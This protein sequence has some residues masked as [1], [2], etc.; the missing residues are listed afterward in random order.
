MHSQHG[1]PQ[2][3]HDQLNVIG[4]HLWHLKH[5]PEFLEDA[6]E[7]LPLLEVLRTD[8]HLVSKEEQTRL[9]K[10]LKFSE[11]ERAEFSNLFR[12]YS[13]K[14]Q[15]KLTRELLKRREDW[16]D[17]ETSEDK[18]LQQYF[19]QD[20]FG[21]PQGRPPGTNLLSLL[22]VYLVKDDGR[23]KARCVCNGSKNCRGTVT[24]AETYASSLEQNAARLFW[25]STALNNWITIGAGAANAFA[26][27]KGPVAPLYVYCDEQFRSWYH[28]KFPD[29]PEVRKGMVM[30]V[31][32]ALQGHPESP[33]LWAQL[34]DG[35]ISDL[36]LKACS[37]EPNLYYTD[38]YNNTGKK[39]LLLRQV[40]DFAIS[41]ADRSLAQDV[42]DAIDSK[43]SI[44]VT[45]LGLITR[46]N[47]IDVD[48]TRDCI[49][50][51][52]ATYIDKFVKKHSWILDDA[53]PMASF[54]L[55]MASDSAYVTKLEEADPMSDKER[56]SLETSLG[57][58]Y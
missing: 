42:I 41:C 33:R 2:L 39:L 47:G 19:D 7:F 36:N 15:R 24:Q 4:E 54:P 37:H 30:R 53:H 35:I 50:L 5:D 56:I 58:S 32:R 10:A 55:P 26:E 18:Q 46:F 52:N 6:E 11:E 9:F 3:Y 34:I 48:Q 40:D 16:I 44:K 22:W 57:F 17:W 21:E 23:K 27:A 29:R 14:K 28:R 38:N 12:V 8:P 1:I 13:V 45:E 25:A 51:S 31:K 49:K 20:T 43:M